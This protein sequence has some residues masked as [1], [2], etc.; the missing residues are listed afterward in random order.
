MEFEVKA[1]AHALGCSSEEILERVGNLP[2]AQHRLEARTGANGARRFFALPRELH[3]IHDELAPAMAMTDG[4]V[5]DL[6]ARDADGFV[7]IRVPA[8]GP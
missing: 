8:S 5:V 1:V 3:L 2:V 6:L 7:L 4:K